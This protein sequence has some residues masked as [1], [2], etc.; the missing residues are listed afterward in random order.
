MKKLPLAI[1]FFACALFASRAWSDKDWQPEPGA[2]KFVKTQEDPKDKGGG[3]KGK[4]VEVTGQDELKDYSDG[5][6]YEG[7]QFQE[8]FLIPQTPEDYKRIA[9]RL[10]A[11]IAKASK[12]LVLFVYVGEQP[13]KNEK[14]RWKI[15]EKGDTPKVAYLSWLGEAKRGMVG[16]V[17]DI[18]M[19]TDEQGTLYSDLS[20]GLLEN[21][22]KK[23][24]ELKQVGDFRL[25]PK[26]N[27]GETPITCN[28]DSRVFELIYKRLE[29][30]D[31]KEEEKGNEFAKLPENIEKMNEEKSIL[32]IPLD[33]GSI[34]ILAGR[35]DHVL[36]GGLKPS[37]DL[38]LTSLSLHILVPDS[39]VK[40]AYR[41]KSVCL[42]PSK[43]LAE[44]PSDTEQCKKK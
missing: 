9:K 28:L 32:G 17:G 18:L 7:P 38:K 3:L 25:N 16:I 22:E 31:E 40:D 44:G 37:P 19:T 29:G 27:V 36:R 10:N 21:R 11:E 14:E 33:G 39:A 15:L 30:L 41:S 24:Y 4:P 20:K 8:E 12:D 42:Y 6:D 35:G 2:F 34:S 23:R 13:L 5:S 1:L 26:K 43:R